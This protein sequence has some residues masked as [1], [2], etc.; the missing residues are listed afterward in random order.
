MK[1][2]RKE[3]LEQ[4]IHDCYKEMY[5]KAQPSIDF[6]QI[7]QEFKEG[8]RDKDERVYEQHYLSQDE[9]IYIVDKYLDAYN[10]RSHWKDDVEVVEEYLSKGGLKDVYIP[11]T[12]DEH[13]HHP[14]HRSATKVPPIKEQ[15]KNI[16]DTYQLIN[17]DKKELIEE[18]TNVVMKTIKEC[19]DFYHFDREESS[20]R[21]TAALGASPTSNPETV[22][23]YWKEKT[24]ED[25]QIEERNPKL[26]W[27]RDMEYTDEDLEEEF[28]DPNWKENLDKEWKE[29]I[30]KKEKEHQERIKRIQE[31]I[32][33]YES[34]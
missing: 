19:K 9:Y 18:L 28:D 11:D 16:V 32:D 2:S 30:A 24:G 3:I 27:Y 20:F 17:Q 25:I 7:V 8:K 4:A 14:G 13:G 26:F 23:E 33:A 5:A 6:D 34:K 15:I 1:V 12:E 21:I 22:K 31:N 10:I 29:E